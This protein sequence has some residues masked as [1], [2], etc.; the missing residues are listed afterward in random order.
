MRYWRN[1]SRT[2]SIRDLL[3]KANGNWKMWSFYCYVRIWKEK[4]S[5]LRG[6]W[7]YFSI[8]TEMFENFWYFLLKVLQVPG[9]F[10][11]KEEILWILFRFS[12]IFYKMINNDLEFR[13]A[14]FVGNVDQNLSLHKLDFFFFGILIAYK[15]QQ[16]RVQCEFFIVEPQLQ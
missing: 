9:F 8:Y 15:L 2:I 1:N 12:H 11:Y 16:K 13:H 4:T 10:C 3:I 6:Y 7:R 5:I 14:F